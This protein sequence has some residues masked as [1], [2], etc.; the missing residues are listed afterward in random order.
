MPEPSNPPTA[1]TAAG[2][3]ILGFQGEE[4]T[5]RCPADAGHLEQRLAQAKRNRGHRFISRTLR[6]CKPSHR[7]SRA[8]SNEPSSMGNPKVPSEFRPRGAHC[9]LN[10]YE[11]AGAIF[12][13]LPG[14]K[15]TL[16]FSG[17]W[18][19]NAAELESWN[20]TQEDYGESDTSPAE[21][22]ATV[23]TPFRTVELPPMLMEVEFRDFR[24]V[25][26]A[27]DDPVLERVKDNP[28]VCDGRAFSDG[29]RSLTVT[30]QKDGSL[31]GFSCRQESSSYSQLV[32]DLADQGFR[33]PSADEWEY[34][35]AGGTRTL[36]HWGDHVPCDWYPV[37][38]PQR[39]WNKHREPNGF[40]LSIAR[41][42]YELELLSQ[43]GI[44]RGGDGGCNVCGAVGFFMGWLPLAS[45]WKDGFPYDAGEPLDLGCYFARRVLE[46][47]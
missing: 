38:P 9:G 20:D 33:L 7:G 21:Y 1:A 28:A 8:W 34:A 14:G 4:L 47:S 45:S 44:S 23:T 27:K 24:W 5:T 41:N 13:L 11:Y 46:L 35:C 31:I 36:F 19:P 29:R 40:G 39:G 26:L 37:D 6:R 43:P 25:P 3:K 15:I 2:S 32:S 12:A 18:A 42:P 17:D 16:G 22:I 10:H 30:R